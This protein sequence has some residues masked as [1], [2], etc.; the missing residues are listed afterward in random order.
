MQTTPSTL[1]PGA[2]VLGPRAGG[3]S[4]AADFGSVQFRD[5]WQALSMAREAVRQVPESEAFAAA[6]ALSNQLAQLIELQ[7]LEARRIGGRVAAEAETHARFLKAAL[8]DEVLLAADWPGRAYW[9]QLLLEA[10]LFR[11]TQAGEKV[12]EAIDQILVT[13]DA[14][15]R[16]LARLYLYVLSLGFQGRYRGADDI[17]CLGDYRRE[18]YQFIY[19]RPADLH[20]RD[21]TLSPG[22]YASTLGHVRPGKLRRFS[23]SRVVLALVMVGLLALSQVLW[24]WRSWPVR[25]ALDEV[26]GQALASGWLG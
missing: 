17:D 4:A 1:N 10:R 5:F 14:S 2:L 7:T 13:R 22:A 16:D 18:L 12:F 8:A 24:L 15:Q 11:T 23:R 26:V 25:R 19:Q 6:Q 20:G 9:G 3:A 21:R